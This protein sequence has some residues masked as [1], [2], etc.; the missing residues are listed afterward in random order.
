MRRLRARSCWR[1]ALV[2]VLGRGGDEGLV[3]P[4]LVGDVGQPGVEQDEVGAGIDREMHD[5]V[6]AGLDFAGID[7]DR[8]ARVDDDDARLLER[9]GSELGL[10]LVHRRAAQ[11]R[12]PVVEEIVGLGLERVGADRDDGVGELGILV[13]VVEFA[14]AHVARGM[15]LGIVG[16]PVVDADVLDLHR[17]E[18]ELAGAPGVLVAAAGA[19]V[20]EGRDEQPVLALSLMTAT[21]TRATRSSASSQLVGCI[22]P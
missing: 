12:N 15:D 8:A 11:V 1:R 22:W 13:A 9:L 5:V 17:P 16:R 2:E 7:R 10:L 4:A 3:G 18:I 20:I 19:A 6:L 14:D 21:V